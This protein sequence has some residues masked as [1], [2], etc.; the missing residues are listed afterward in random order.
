MEFSVSFRIVM[1][2]D[3]GISKFGSLSAM[4]I[5]IEA[6]YT[7]EIRAFQFSTIN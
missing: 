5:A 7:L 4:R 6:N 3:T 2:V 1:K